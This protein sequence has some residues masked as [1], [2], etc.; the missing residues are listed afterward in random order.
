[1]WPWVD[2]VVD[3]L[4][5]LLAAEYPAKLAEVAAARGLDTIE[6]PVDYWPCDLAI[7]PAYPAVEIYSPDTTLPDPESSSLQYTHRLTVVVSVVGTDEVEIMRRSRLMMLALV[8]VLFDRVLTDSEVRIH[9]GTVNFALV[10]GSGDQD[11]PWYRAS[12]LDLTVTTFT[13]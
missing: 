11:D 13:T 12:S 5:A 10:D 8:L 7:P 9:L 4:I 1:M 6:P 3:E 2:T